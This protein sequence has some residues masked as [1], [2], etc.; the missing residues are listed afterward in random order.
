VIALRACAAVAGAVLVVGTVSSAVR[1]MVV[2]RGT[3]STIARAVFVGLRYLFRALTIR[4]RDDEAQDRIM[5]LYAPLGLVTLPVAWL[6]IVL[7]G[8]TLLYWALDGGSLRDA[9]R[10]SGSSLFTLGFAA[11]HDLPTL[12]LA[13]TEAGAGVG[14]LALLIT[15]LP[16]STTPRSTGS[17]TSSPS[18][19]VGNLAS[20]EL[21][22]ATAHRATGEAPYVARASSAY[23][24]DGAGWKL[25][26]HQQT[27]LSR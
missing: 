8:Y 15:Y 23:V 25:A 17:E 14:L 9:L 24:R 3:P 5:A 11:P 1:T 10:L 4:R 13:L 22:F 7:G 21:P 19:L 26:F 16:T 20:M 2:P 6:T 27:P 18:H 12:A